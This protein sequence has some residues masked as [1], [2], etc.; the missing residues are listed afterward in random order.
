MIFVLFLRLEFLWCDAV[1]MVADAQTALD[2]LRESKDG[3]QFDIH[4]QNGRLQA[5]RAHRPR[6]GSL[7]HSKALAQTHFSTFMHGI[8]LIVQRI[9]WCLDPVT[10]I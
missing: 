5:P 4:A 6:D 10:K 8:L 2:M 9:R 1:T 3:N 7:S